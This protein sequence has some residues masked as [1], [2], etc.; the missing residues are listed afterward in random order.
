MDAVQLLRTLR[1]LRKKRPLFAHGYCVTVRLN[2]YVTDVSFSVQIK[3]LDFVA[4][5]V[6]LR[7]FCFLKESNTVLGFSL[8]GPMSGAAGGWCCW[9]FLDDCVVE[10]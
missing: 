3:Q 1:L 2:S 9:L 6:S 10:W 4:D 5:H 7:Y 8:Y